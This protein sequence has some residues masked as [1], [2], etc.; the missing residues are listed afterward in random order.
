[1]RSPSTGT[2][3][4]QEGVSD[5]F[6]NDLP[7]YCQE[8]HEQYDSYLMIASRPIGGVESDKLRQTVTVEPR[9]EKVSTS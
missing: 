4:I 5:A 7:D 2:R 6:F 1:M 9:L 3:P 8:L